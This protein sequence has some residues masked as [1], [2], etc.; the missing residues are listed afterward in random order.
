MENSVMEMRREIEDRE[1][2]KHEM[3]EDKKYVK[4]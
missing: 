2:L 1:K 4:Q 3:G